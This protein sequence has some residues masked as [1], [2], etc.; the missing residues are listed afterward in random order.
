[1]GRPRSLRSKAAHFVTDIT[2]GLLNP[3]S[4]K[5]SKP[6]PFSSSYEEDVDGSRGSQNGTMS[7][8]SPANPVDGPD[9]SS[10]T[11]FLYSLLS[12]SG[13][14]DKSK[15][16]DEQ[17][18]DQMDKS[19]SLSDSA[20]KANSGKRSLFSKGEHTLSKAMYQAARFGWY[21]SQERKGNFDVKGDDGNDSEFTRVEM[22]HMHKAQKPV[23]LVHL[24]D[25]SVPSLLNE[26]NR[27]ALYSSL[28]AL[29][30]GSQWLLLYR[31]GNLE[32][33]S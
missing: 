9:T 27:I 19:N 29:V 32:F 5:P 16:S 26:K 31:W 10:F 33:H 7:E 18:D 2:T 3:I 20:V 12:S 21:R 8:E 15:S 30:Q 1:M 4:D 25:V 28:P 17:V 22:R 24:P 6:S 23:A 11:A 13:S 14:G